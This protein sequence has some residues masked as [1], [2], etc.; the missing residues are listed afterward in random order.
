MV[1]AKLRTAAGLSRADL[2]KAVA[3]SASKIGRIENLESGIYRDDIE[4]LLDFYE[5][6]SPRRVELLDLARHTEERGWLWMRGGQGLSEDWQTWIDLE[7]EAS[8]I[9]NYQPLM[10]PGLLQTPDYARAIIQATGLNLSEVEVDASVSSRMARQTRLNQTSPMKLHALIEESVLMRPCGDADAWMRQLRHLIDS[11]T[12][13]NIAIQVLPIDSGLHSALNG[14]FVILEYK[15]KTKLV[16]LE[17]K[18]SNL[19]LDEDEQ[20][21]A[22]AQTWAELQ[23]LACDAEKSVKLIS[24]IAARQHGKT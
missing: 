3:M 18:V 17:G 5:I 13:P 11:A 2:A 1:L 7:A 9:F 24:A 15:D 12:R 23:E 16:H 19:F 6:S 20:I 14:S 10:I 22:Y 21:Q 8:K 4:R